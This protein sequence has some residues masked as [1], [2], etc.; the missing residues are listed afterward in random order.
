M[1][2]PA[3]YWIIVQKFLVQGHN[4]IVIVSWGKWTLS[5]KV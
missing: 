3:D 4:V 5:G 2:K 1:K